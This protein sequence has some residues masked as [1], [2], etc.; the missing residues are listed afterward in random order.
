MNEAGTVQVRPAELSRDR[1]DVARLWLEYLSWGNDEMEA[2]HGF[3]LPV[4][5][6][7]E[8]DLAA[9]HKFQ[10]PHGQIVLA[11]CD[12]RV[13]GIG[14]LQRIASDTAEL[15]RMY[16]EP[17]HRRAGA[18]RAMLERLL[19]EAENAGYARV[20]LDSPDFMGSAHALY[21]RHG[22]VDIEPYAESEIPDEYKA[23]WV[24][25]E[26]SKAKDQPALSVGRSFP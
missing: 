25:M 26:R 21:R 12:G 4:R 10:P 18:G 8:R 11:V 16:V 14:C 6:A 22:F 2:R 7:V 3:R 5:E 17:T 19:A 24:F 20:R 9:I 13:C 23:H 15:K 1:D